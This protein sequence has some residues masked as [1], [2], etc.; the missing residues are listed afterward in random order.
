MVRMNGRRRRAALFALLAAVLLTMFVRWRM[1]ALRDSALSQQAADRYAGQSG[2][3]FVQLSIFFHPGDR[4]GE[5]SILLLEETLRTG[6]RRSG[7]TGAGAEDRFPCALS[8]SGYL[9]V[10]SDRGTFPLQAI[11]VG[12]DFFLFH[13]FRLRY[14][15]LMDIPAG[16]GIVVNDRAAWLLFGG[17]DVVGLPVRIGVDAYV[18]SGVV[19]LENDRGSQAALGSTDCMIFVPFPLLDT[20][21]TC[22]EVVLPEPVKGYGEALVASLGVGD[23]VNNSARFTAPAIWDA[24]RALPKY[25]MVKSSAPLPYWENAARNTEMRLILWTM[26]LYFCLTPVLA[27]LSLL[28]VIPHVAYVLHW[29]KGRR[30]KKEAMP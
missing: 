28:L 14:G 27:A 5:F 11:G 25:N 12:G 15:S 22:C 24:I 23:T 7:S 1:G 18:V 9:N 13:P 30:G 16:N 4:M 29:I 6:L 17:L 19:S 26:L 20:G 8:A 3:S 2:R 10:Q 21:V